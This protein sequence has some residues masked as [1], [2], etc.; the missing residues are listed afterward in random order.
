ML[1]K[2]KK[3]FMD[4]VPVP[5]P[6]YTW[7]KDE[8]GNVVVHVENRGFYNWL[9]QKFF[10]KPRVSHISLDHYGSFVWQQMDGVRDVFAIS[11]LVEDAFGEEAAPVAP[12]LVRYIQVLYENKF[13][14]YKKETK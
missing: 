4:F 8:K 2:K 7:D 9:A 6:L 14:G 12:R 3:N 5:N 10:K 13:I 1:R 11:K